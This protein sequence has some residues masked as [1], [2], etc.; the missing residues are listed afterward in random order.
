MCS[1]CNVS[2]NAAHRRSRSLIAPLVIAAAGVAAAA[3]AL[4]SVVGRGGRA[5][6]VTSPSLSLAN[7]RDV[8]TGRAIELRQSRALVEVW[9]AA[10][11][12]CQRQARVLVRF[13]RRHPELQLVA[14]DLQD[15]KTRALA[16]ARRYGWPGAL[17]LD[18]EA[19]LAE[20]L[21]LRSLPATVLVDHGRTYAPPSGATPSRTLARRYDAILEGRVSGASAAGSAPLG[22]R[23]GDSRNPVGTGADRDRFEQSPGR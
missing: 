1:S 3:F 23:R 8:V 12:A 2:T 7:S 9:S 16:L 15:S 11:P 6:S 17:L 20:R 5:G 4:T 13:A 18:P 22:G 10:C 19:E 21:R 14:V